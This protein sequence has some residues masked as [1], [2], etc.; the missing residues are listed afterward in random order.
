ME[1]E[2]NGMQFEVRGTLME[3]KVRKKFM[4]KVEAASPSRATEILFTLLGSAQK[5]KRRSISIDSV[6]EVK[7]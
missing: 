5:L 4:K 1:D 3:K 7:A 2:V 6:K